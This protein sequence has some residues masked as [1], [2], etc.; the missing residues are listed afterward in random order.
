MR[1]DRSLSSHGGVSRRQFLRGG[2]AAA[3][4]LVVASTVPAWA[5]GTKAADT[6]LVNGEVWTVDASMPWASAVAIRNGRIVFVG[7]DD[8]ARAFVGAG[9]EVIN[10]RGRMAMPGIHDGHIHP[11]SGGRTLT[12]ASLNYAQLTLPQFLD[13]IAGFLAATVDQEPDTWLTVGQ[14]DAIAMTKVAMPPAVSRVRSCWAATRRSAV[15][16][17]WM[18]SSRRAPP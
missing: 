18:W 11:L 8:D 12:A 9:T 2:A 1:T 4:G 15:Q 3:G 10:L 17:G 13:R 16:S 7:K 6:V 5:R 14:W